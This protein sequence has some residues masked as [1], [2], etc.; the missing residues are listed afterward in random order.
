MLYIGNRPVGCND[1]Q[2]NVSQPI[3][4]VFSVHRP[5]RDEPEPMVNLTIDV[6]TSELLL[7]YNLDMYTY[8]SILTNNVN[9]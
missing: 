6:A 1:H 7:N 9:A 3:Q 8:V 4:T 5:S 2:V